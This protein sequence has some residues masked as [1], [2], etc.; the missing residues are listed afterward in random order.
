M[1]EKYHGNG[2]HTFSNQRLAKA[3]TKIHPF[4]PIEDENYD[5]FYVDEDD[6]G[7]DTYSEYAER[8]KTDWFRIVDRQHTFNGKLLYVSNNTN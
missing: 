4:V 1:Q 2:W 7:A 8:S 5:V 3:E 6:F